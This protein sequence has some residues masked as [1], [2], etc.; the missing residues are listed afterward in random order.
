LLAKLASSGKGGR[1]RIVIQETLKTP[2][3]TTGYTEE[4][5]Q[6][7]V[8]EGGRRGHQSLTQEMLRAPR[9]CAYDLLVGDSLHVCL[10]DEGET[11]MTPYWRYLVD[12]LLPLE[13]AEAMVVKKNTSRYTLVDGNLFRHG[14]THPIMSCV[15][16]EQCTR[17]MA[18]LH[19][20]IC[21]SY[22]GGRALSS[23]V[24]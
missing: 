21:G 7:S 3:T 6:V 5:Q 13:P 18:E 15:S 2:R 8:S 17:I 12:G 20:G 14:Y 4:V 24:V 1:Q 19:E 9:I 22:I 23:K 10:V 16:G 11:W